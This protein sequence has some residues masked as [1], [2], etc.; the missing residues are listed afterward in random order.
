MMKKLWERTRFACPAFAGIVLVLASCQKLETPLEG[1]P[2]VPAGEQERSAACWQW[3]SS[4]AEREFSRSQPDPGQTFG[5]TIPL[6]ERFDR[7]DAEKR[8][9]ALY[10]RCM[11]EGSPEERP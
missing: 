9:Q 10:Q 7:F 2:Q 5:R 8:R 6:R 4:R 1:P 11:A 3:A